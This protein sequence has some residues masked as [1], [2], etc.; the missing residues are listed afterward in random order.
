M[1]QQ[2]VLT[3][4]SFGPLA[5]TSQ[6]DIDFHVSRFVL[7]EDH[8]IR[9][10]WNVWLFGLLLYTA[11][12]LPPKLAFFDFG[13]PEREVPEWYGWVEYV[14]LDGGFCI[15][16][17][18]N[19]FCT[20]RDKRGREVVSHRR[21]I[22]KY[23]C[24]TFL[25]NLIACF[26]P[27]VLDH[28]FGAGDSDGAVPGGGTDAH[29]S[30]RL[31]R[32]QKVSK[33]ARLVRLLR[34][35]KIFAFMTN[36]P[37]WAKLQGVRGVRVL[38]LCG[39]LLFLVHLFACGWWICASAHDDKTHTW[40]ARRAIQADGTT[41]L[42]VAASDNPERVTAWEQ[43]LTCMYLILTVFTSVGFG[44]FNGATLGEMAFLCVTMLCGAVANGILLSEVITTLMVEDDTHHMLKERQQ[45]LESFA[46][47][48][49]LGEKQTQ[50]LL[51]WLQ[52][53]RTSN[54]VYNRNSTK[55]LIVGSGIPRH[56]LS[57]VK[58]GLFNGQFVKQKFVNACAGWNGFEGLPPRFPILVALAGDIVFFEHKQVVYYKG[59]QVWSLYLVMGGTFANVL[60]PE[61]DID[62]FTTSAAQIEASAVQSHVIKSLRTETSSLNSNALLG[63]ISPRVRQSSMALE[64]FRPYHLY[65]MNNYFGDAEL[66]LQPS[67]RKCT[68]RCESHDGS[69]LTL[70]KKDV[71]ELLQEWPRFAEAWRSNARRRE[72]HR[73]RCQAL[74]KESQTFSHEHLAIRNMQRHFRECLARRRKGERRC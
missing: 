37:L 40:L 30:T 24:G 23:L 61:G 9:R 8:I 58:Q 64:D 49:R 3:L 2:R 12:L 13:V 10:V 14:A 51:R 31:A 5:R 4:N 47:H 11:I 6:R 22:V 43:W 16:L 57:L 1:L 35:A 54:I 36:S 68:A 72:L 66:F 67:Q 71:G 29:Q 44:D 53:A 52:S 48:T 69:L 39:S 28:I 56:L 17:I 33:L 50:K 63:G 62:A 7:Q 65:G 32:V 21:I 45:M 25:L 59:D 70:P 42:D 26:P 46:E 18:I 19:F 34:M 15:D 60:P 41:L 73:I 55:E 38:N 74:H 20:Y 27:Q